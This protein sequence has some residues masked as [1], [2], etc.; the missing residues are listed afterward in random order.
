VRQLDTE[1]RIMSLKPVAAILCACATLSGVGRAAPAQSP[2]SDERPPAGAGHKTPSPDGKV[3]A[4]FYRDGWDE[5]IA[6]HDTGSG[7]ELRRITGHGD[8]VREFR[9]TP[10]GKTLASRSHR[11]WKLWD[12]ATGKLLLKLPLPEK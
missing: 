2:A 9:F 3:Y 10:D 8:L 6:V 12:V 7:K 11:D 4:V 1:G 5:T